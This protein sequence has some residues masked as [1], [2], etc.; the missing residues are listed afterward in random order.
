MPAT[1]TFRTER[2]LAERLR[3]E[4]LDELR[5]MDRDPWVMATL[6][7]V[8]L[9]DETRRA[10]AGN[11]D[12]WDRH[13]FGIWTFRDSLDG[14]FVGRGGLRNARVDGNDEVE[15]LYAL[16]AEYWGK[17]LATELARAIL[18]VGFEQLGLA[19]VTCFTLPTNRASRR[20]ME[21]V[22]FTYERDMLHAGLPHVLYRITAAEWQ[23]DVSMLY[24]RY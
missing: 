21:K 14:R 4:D 5:R 10:L 11:L 2:L 15:L 18:T 16:R 17:G 19:D 13:G 20:V 7:G 3:A 12:H 6:G 24:P 1:A 9:D 23:D 8:R 22:A